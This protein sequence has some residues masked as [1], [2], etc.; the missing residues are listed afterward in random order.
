M[1]A[2]NELAEMAEDSKWKPDNK[3][4]VQ[5]RAEASREMTLAQQALG[6]NAVEAI[7]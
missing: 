7:G 6:L 2:F 4:W 3:K 1:V 5:K